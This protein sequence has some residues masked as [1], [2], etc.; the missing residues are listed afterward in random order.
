MTQSEGNGREP[1]EI[2]MPSPSI[3]PPLLALSLM[4]LLVGIVL[5][6]GPLTV[7]GVIAFV[8]VLGGWL[9][10]GE[11]GRWVGR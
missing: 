8:V 7:V 10:E 5:Y 1:H 2:H 9:F 4:L 3:W 6:R 11:L